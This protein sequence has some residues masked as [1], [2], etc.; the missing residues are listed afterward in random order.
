MFLM[1]GSLM[2]LC[3]C[4]TPPVVVKQSIVP[5]AETMIKAEPVQ[6]FTGKKVGDLVESYLN[7]ITQYRKLSIRHNDLVDWINKNNK[8]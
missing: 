1:L 8:N 7:L 5:P 4:S 6:P 2:T 3:G